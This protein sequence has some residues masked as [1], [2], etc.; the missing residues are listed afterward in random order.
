MRFRAAVVRCVVWRTGE[1]DSFSVCRRLADA[2]TPQRHAPAQPS[3]VSALARFRARRD[4]GRDA[5]AGPRAR[6]HSLNADARPCR[7]LGDPPA[8][9]TNFT[10]PRTPSPGRLAALAQPTIAL[11]R[12]GPSEGAS[13]TQR[14]PSS[15]LHRTAM[16][17]SARK[18]RRRRSRAKSAPGW[19]TGRRHCPCTAGT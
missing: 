12:H 9:R 6:A 15:R 2:T 18:A 16:A 4:H 17:C 13:L 1:L 10:Q 8:P 14:P 5:T 7:L 19:H 3:P 11:P